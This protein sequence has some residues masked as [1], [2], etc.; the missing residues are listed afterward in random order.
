MEDQELDLR[1][2]LYVLR[3]RFLLLVALPVAAAV[4]AGLVSQFLLTPIYQASTTLWV[5]KDDTAQ[6]SY[7]DLLLSRNLTTTYAE[8]AKSRTVMQGVINGLGLTG[9]TPEDLQEKVTVTAVRNTEILSIAVEDPDPVRAAQLADAVAAAF[10]EQIHSFMKVENV[11]VVDP[12]L[13][14]T[15]PVRPR[16]AMNVAVAF[17]LGAMAAVGLA[18]LLEFLDTSVRTPEDV[19]RHLGLPVLASIPE[20]EAVDVPLATTDGSR[21]RKRAVGE[22]RVEL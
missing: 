22:R 17:V 14:P 10:I 5:I 7:N 21:A 18:F 19:Q 4:L 9:L 13:V 15:E 11:A 2:L 20:F 6:I 16:K 1:E 8:V 12:A 3:R